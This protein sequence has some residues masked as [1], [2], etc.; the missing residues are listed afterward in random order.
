MVGNDDH[1][2][3][4]PDLG[5]FAKLPLEHADGPRPADIMRHQDVGLHPNIVAGLN[6]GFARRAGQY[7]LCQS[8]K[9]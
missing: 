6:P 8:H 2:V 9:P 7:C 4:V 3:A 1:L 5:G